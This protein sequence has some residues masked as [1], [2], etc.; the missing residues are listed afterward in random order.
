LRAGK[1]AFQCVKTLMCCHG[2]RQ[3]LLTVYT[4]SPTFAKEGVK[5]TDYALV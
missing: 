4:A 2:G 3:S 5:S 1:S